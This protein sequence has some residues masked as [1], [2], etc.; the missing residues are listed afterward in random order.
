MQYN[1]ALHPDHYLNA[2]K[3]YWELPPR[4]DAVAVALGARAQ[5]PGD[6]GGMVESLSPELDWNISRMA[7]GGCRIRN[8]IAASTWLNLISQPNSRNS[9]F[10]R[11]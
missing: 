11:N 8:R 6:S 1:L 10:N 4:S 3:P 9:C 7:R 2:G 5:A